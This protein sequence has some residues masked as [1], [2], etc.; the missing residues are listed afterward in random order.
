[1][2]A[3]EMMLNEHLLARGDRTPRQ[4]SP[5]NA[6]GDVDDENSVGRAI[7]FY[8]GHREGRGGHHGHGGHRGGALGMAFTA[9]CILMMKIFM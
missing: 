4:H 6:H 3:M 7:Y 1:M 8:F 9:V 5:A 2:S